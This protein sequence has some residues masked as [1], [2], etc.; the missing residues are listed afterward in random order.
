MQA[1]FGFGDTERDEMTQQYVSRTAT[2]IRE[3]FNAPNYVNLEQLADDMLD[4]EEKRMRVNL[5]KQGLEAQFEKMARE[6]SHDDIEG[7]KDGFPTGGSSGKKDDSDHIVA[8]V[9]LETV[10]GDDGQQVD[11]ERNLLESGEQYPENQTSQLDGSEES[12]LEDGRNEVVDHGDDEIGEDG[13]VAV[14][15]EPDTKKR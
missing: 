8:P 13:V 2:Q 5:V 3:A 12:H 4:E 6:D 10:A 9:G 15:V 7:E 14:V 11:G 1:E